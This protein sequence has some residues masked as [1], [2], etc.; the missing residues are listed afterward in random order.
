VADEKGEFIT[1]S[2]A[3]VTQL[4]RGRFRFVAM[5]FGFVGGLL[6]LG[7]LVFW[8]VVELVWYI[9]GVFLVGGGILLFIAAN[10]MII[11][12]GVPSLRIY[13][14]GVLI[15]PPKGKT[16]FHPWSSFEGYA[17]KEMGPAEVIEL[18]PPKGEAI[19][20]HQYTDKYARIKELVQGDVPLVE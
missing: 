6:L 18:R 13:E 5:L 19:S 15:K 3:Q 7:G 16:I 1:E 9:Y 11:S 2:S 12:K 4:I 8:L 10:L 20:I 14:G 17:M